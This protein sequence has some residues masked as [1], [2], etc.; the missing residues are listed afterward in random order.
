MADRGG[1]PGE[2]SFAAGGMAGTAAS[3]ALRRVRALAD[4]AP[5][6]RLFQA[7]A[8]L[9]EKS[10]NIETE[11]ESGSE[12]LDRGNDN[13]ATLHFARAIVR[14]DEMAANATPGKQSPAAQLPDYLKKRR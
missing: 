12:A 11:L 14:M 5:T 7:I 4:A 3:A 13:D 9:T 6:G 2:F 1:K 8:T 10:R